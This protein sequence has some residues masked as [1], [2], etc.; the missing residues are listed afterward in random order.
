MCKYIYIYIIESLIINSITITRN[1]LIQYSSTIQPVVF[2]NPTELQKMAPQLPSHLLCPHS[3]GK[4]VKLASRNTSSMDHE[5]YPPRGEITT[6]ACSISIIH[7]VYRIH[8]LL[9]KKHKE[10]IHTKIHVTDFFG[11]PPWKAQTG[12][13]FVINHHVYEEL[14]FSYHQLANN[15]ICSI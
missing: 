15:Q 3:R 9:N 1:L 5:S 4:G 7:I 11:E 12:T 6:I 10:K 8:F 14:I 2:S 13:H